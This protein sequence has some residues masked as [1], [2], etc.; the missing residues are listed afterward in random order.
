MVKEIGSGLE[1]RV[2][3]RDG[4]DKVANAVK[5]THGARGR[6]VAIGKKFGQPHVTKDG[7]TVARAIEELE[8]P[9]EQI[10]AQMVKG[11][12]VKTAELAGDGTTTASVL[13]QAI[14]TEGVKNVTAGANPMD[15]KRG[16]DKAVEAVVSQLGKIS[17]KVT[18]NKQLEQ[19]AVISANGDSEIGGLIAKAMGKIGKDGAIMVEESKSSETTIT[20]DEGVKFNRGY[21]SKA[22]ITDEAKS[23]AVLNNPLILMVS[24]NLTDINV[25]IPM[26]KELEALKQPILII[27]NDFDPRVLEVFAINKVKHHMEVAL[28][29]APFVSGK[30]KDFLDD[31]AVFTGGGVIS[32]EKGNTFG[33]VVE[34]SD[35]LKFNTALFGGCS[36]IIINQDSTIIKGGLGSKSRIKDRKSMI[37]TL[38]KESTQKFDED[39]LKGRLSRISGGVATLFVG[40]SSEVELK[41]KKDR[42][43]DAIAATKAASEE[44][45]VAGGGVALINVEDC[46]NEVK[47]SNDDEQTGVN[48]IKR[49]IREPIKNI[50][51]NS[52]GFGEVIILGIKERPLGTGYNVQTKEFVP[53][54]E[55][56]IIDPVK[57]TRVA[58]ENA[59]S[60][61]GLILTTECTITDKKD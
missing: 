57:V 27:A 58:L 32:E 25:L 15:L 8:D 2:K 47:V 5:V 26:F 3:L 9:I 51:H 28:V 18:S 61:G 22:F 50:V 39:E 21:T 1:T 29:K 24:G 13:T 33:E 40:A 38:I 48:I 4:V 30:R 45:I 36:K 23:E 59:A 19:I 6:N 11:V 44:G 10:G 20:I 37:S 41:E 55:S 31:L 35:D 54:I 34:G 17:K 7:A 52:G 12:A 16:I 42:V 43:D 56:G 14:V 53:M 46:L 60:V 49:A